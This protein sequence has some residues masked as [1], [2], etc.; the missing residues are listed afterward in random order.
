MTTDIAA[1]LKLPRATTTCSTVVYLNRLRVRLSEAM[2]IARRAGPK[3]ATFLA[4][5]A[6]AKKKTMTRSSSHILARDDAG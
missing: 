2:A 5:L 6:L 4:T 1:L 3:L